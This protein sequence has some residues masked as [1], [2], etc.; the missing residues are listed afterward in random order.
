MW[1]C[2][3]NIL[4]P[5][6]LLLHF[7]KNLLFIAHCK[8]QSSLPHISINVKKMKSASIECLVYIS[9]W[10]YSTR[11]K[12]RFYCMLCWNGVQTEKGRII[13]YFRLSEAPCSVT[14][15]TITANWGFSGSFNITKHLLARLI[16]LKHRPSFI[17]FK[18]K[19]IFVV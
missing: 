7:I 18:L 6:P 19:R 17:L 2:I 1:V 10:N 8:R 16:V 3:K 4:V 15:F 11:D 14:L 13:P 9:G 5:L 12:D